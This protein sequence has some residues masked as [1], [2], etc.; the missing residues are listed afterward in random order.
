MDEKTKEDLIFYL[1]IDSAID[2]TRIATI[3]NKYSGQKIY[4]DKNIIKISINRLPLNAG[5]YYITLF[6]EGAGGVYDWIQK[7]AIF[8]VKYADYYGK[9][10]QLPPQSLGIVLLDYKIS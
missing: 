1:S 9:N 4:S 6:V 10:G 5:D 8:S 2:R 7:A 3:S